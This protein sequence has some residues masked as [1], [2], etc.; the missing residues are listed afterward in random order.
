MAKVLSGF[1]P[2]GKAFRDGILAVY[3]LSPAETELLDQAARTVDLIA[4]M[5]A[6]LAASKLT[7][8]GST[9]NPRPHPLLA[10]VAEQRRLL[11]RLVDSMGLPQPGQ[12]EGT[13]NAAASTSS[14]ATLGLAAPGG[15]LMAT[16][17]PVEVSEVPVEVA[18]YNPSVHG[19]GADG[20]V[21]W[22]EAALGWLAA[23]PGRGLPGGIADRLAVRRKSVALRTGRDLPTG[24]PDDAG[25]T[26]IV[27]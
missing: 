2:R 6:E 7:V 24:L 15:R 25:V 3:T 20:I 1:G 22:R 12:A 18:E 16:W 23:H 27:W 26:V 21:R 11:G 17:R 19:P 5:D 4:A 13:R 10:S 8:A 14:T 9:G